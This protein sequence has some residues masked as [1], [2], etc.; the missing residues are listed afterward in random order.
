M[1][2]IVLGFDY[3][4]KNNVFFSNLTLMGDVVFISIWNS[5]FD[6]NGYD[7]NGDGVKDINGGWID[8]S[9]NVDELNFIFDNGSK[10]VGQVIYNVVET[11]VM[12]DVVINS[13]IF[14]VIYEN[15]DWKRVVDD[16]VFQ[17]GVFNVALNNGFEW[18]II[19]RFIVD[20]LIVNN[21]FQVNVSEFKLILDIIDL[22]N[23]FSLN[24]GE[25]GYVDIDY[26]IINF[27][28]IVALIEFIGWGVD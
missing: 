25:D 12:Y 7:F 13:F 16:K 17:S 1:F 14:D 27:Y 8:D 15:N 19:G 18:D 26:L 28:S 5:N 11:L 23:G 2:F 4:M 10:W 21:G 6:S 22:I 20:I 24:I 3:A 9:F